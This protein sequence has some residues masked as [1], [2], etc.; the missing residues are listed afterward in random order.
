MRISSASVAAP[1]S[2]EVEDELE[3]GVEGGDKPVALLFASLYSSGVTIPLRYG[4]NELPSSLPPDAD[5]VEK[6]APTPTLTRMNL[7]RM[8]RRSNRR[9][10]CNDEVPGR[11]VVGW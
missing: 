9:S 4:L 7:G 5:V 10:T 6:L 2:D 1:N 8:K 11:E 3:D